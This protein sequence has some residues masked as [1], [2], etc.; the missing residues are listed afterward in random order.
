MDCI[1]L[2]LPLEPGV[3]Y[4]CLGGFIDVCLVVSKLFPVLFVAEDEVG[5][6]DKAGQENEEN[7]NPFLLF[8]FLKHL[9][10]FEVEV[11][12]ENENP[13]DHNI[14]NCASIPVN[15]SIVEFDGCSE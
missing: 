6:S 1:F 2:A 15:K 11:V 14:F 4:N 5:A 7:L 3:G 8:E 13:F 10:V 12:S 9:C